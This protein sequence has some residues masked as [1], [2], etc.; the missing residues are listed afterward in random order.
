MHCGPSLER[1][2]SSCKAI[3]A[4]KVLRVVKAMQANRILNLA[5][6]RI[7]RKSVP[8]GNAADTGP[9]AGSG[10][11]QGAQVGGGLTI[12]W[13]DITFAT[14]ES[15]SKDGGEVR[16]RDLQDAV[17][18]IVDRAVDLVVDNWIICGVFGVRGRS[19]DAA[20]TSN[21]WLEPGANDALRADLALGGI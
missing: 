12:H 1:L 5:K 11:E 9:R 2:G 17:L 13:N 7:A 20:L 4:V 6:A 19:D 18:D 21:G 15:L 8:R 14:I 10:Q 3:K 16:Y